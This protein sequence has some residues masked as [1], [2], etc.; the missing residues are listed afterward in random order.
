MLKPRY[1]SLSEAVKDYKEMLLGMDERH[2]KD[3]TIAESRKSERPA[4]LTESKT[5]K[6]TKVRLEHAPLSRYSTPASAMD[7]FRVL[8]GLT[9]REAMPWNPGVVGTTKT[10]QQILSEANLAPVP[11]EAVDEA[12]YEDENEE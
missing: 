9:E 7:S 3:Q 2:P 4:S 10:N 5:E 8:A 12:E 6:P 1:K 11:T